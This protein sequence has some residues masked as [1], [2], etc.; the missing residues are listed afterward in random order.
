MRSQFFVH[1]LIRIISRTLQQTDNNNVNDY[2]DLV[3]I[4]R[5]TKSFVSNFV[6]CLHGSPQPHSKI[7][8][9]SPIRSSTSTWRLSLPPIS[10]T[11][12]PQPESFLT[13]DVDD[14]FDICDVR[15]IEAQGIYWN[16]SEFFQ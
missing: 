2:T 15:S 5:S 3:Q 13:T 12:E 14:L 4:L 9:V 7:T 6:Q 11:P 16:F 1:L 8:K 10:R